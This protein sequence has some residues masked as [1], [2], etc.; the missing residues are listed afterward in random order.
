MF[1]SMSMVIMQPLANLKCSTIEIMIILNNEPGF[2][3]SPLE[4]RIN[5]AKK[6][7]KTSII[8]EI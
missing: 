5:D 6:G 7:E 2:L 8:I 1:T 3:H 4:N